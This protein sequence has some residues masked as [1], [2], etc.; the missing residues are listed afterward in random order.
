MKYHELDKKV[1]IVNGQQVTI[2]VFEPGIQRRE[3]SWGERVSG[4]KKRTPYRPQS[5]DFKNLKMS[6]LAILISLTVLALIFCSG[7]TFGAHRGY[8]NGMRDVVTLN[9]VSFKHRCEVETD[10]LKKRSENETIQ[11]KE[12]LN[13]AIEYE[14]KLR[15]LPNSGVPSNVN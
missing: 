11:Q 14:Q 6:L 13:N 1:E 4:Q 9:D 3:L 12:R 8:K 7:Y 2:R 10:N 15:A 5:L